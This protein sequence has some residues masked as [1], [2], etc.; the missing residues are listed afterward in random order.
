MTSEQGRSGA[1]ADCVTI[2]SKTEGA[3]ECFEILKAPREIRSVNGGRMFFHSY[4]NSETAKGIACD[5]L[6]INEANNF[7]E[8]QYIDL[9]ASVRCGVIADRNPNGECW[10]SKNGF[11]LL[12]S[13]FKDNIKNLT[14]LQIEYF[15]QLKRNAESPTATDADKYFYKLYYLGEGSELIGDIFTPSN[16]ALTSD[17]KGLSNLFVFCDPSALV[18]NDYFAAV[19][20]GIRNKKLVILDTISTNEDTKQNIIRK[21]KQWCN[22]NDVN[23]IYIEVNGYIGQEFYKLAHKALSI[24]RPYNN[25]VNKFERIVANYEGLTHQMEVVNSDQNKEYLKQ[26][27]EFGKRCPHDDNIDAINSAFE[28]VKYKKLI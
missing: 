15:E 28:I 21:L 22:K 3:D 5:W 1:Y 13:T 11:T 4:Q 23:H 8:L 14:P 7:T 16:I 18:G 10:T 9:A 20:C 24:V 17:T 27:Y 12:H 6:Y 25:K 19:L 26:V 2:L